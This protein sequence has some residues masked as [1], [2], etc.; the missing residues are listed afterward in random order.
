MRQRV[1]YVQMRRVLLPGE[2]FLRR[3]IGNCTVSSFAPRVNGWA[4]CRNPYLYEAQLIYNFTCGV[5]QGAMQATSSRTS[6]VIGPE[7]MRSST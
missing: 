6:G 4:D 3:R 2:L 1:I 5:F 7:H